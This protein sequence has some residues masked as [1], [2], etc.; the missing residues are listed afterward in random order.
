MK[1]KNKKAMSYRKAVKI[2]E[3]AVF[4]NGSSFPVCPQCKQTLER[5]YQAYC[6]RCGQK[7]TW[8]KYNK[9]KL[10]YM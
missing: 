9:A 3:V 4:R 10:V 5:E 1:Q 6:D 8:K 7:L 2:K